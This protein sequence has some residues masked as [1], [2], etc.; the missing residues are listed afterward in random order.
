MGVPLELRLGMREGLSQIDAIVL[1]L[2]G[3]MNAAD[4]DAIFTRLGGDYNGDGRVDAIDYV[5]WRNTVGNSVAPLQR[6][7][8]RR[9]RRDRC[10]R[11][12]DVANE[13]RGDFCGWRERNLSPQC[14]SPAAMLLAVVALMVGWVE[15][16]ET[17][18]R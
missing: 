3:F 10:R 9:Q 17:H 12:C 4:L 15:L 14:L 11:L 6:C 16:R 8:R 7:R 2:D 13:L 1:S 18:R 5:M